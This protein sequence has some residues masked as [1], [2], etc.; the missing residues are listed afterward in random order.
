ME[1]GIAMSN[2]FIWVDTET[3]GLHT[4]AS[5]LEIAVVLTDADL[6]TICEGSWVILQSRNVAEL[7]D[8]STDYVKEMHTKNGLWIDVMNA[9][10]T[11]YE[12]QQIIIN[13]LYENK[14]DPQT[15]PLAGSTILFDRKVI[16]R[17]MPTLDE[18]AHYRSV[19]VSSIKELA[20]VWSPEVYKERPGKEEDKKVHRALDDV[21][22]SIE[23]LKYYRENFLICQ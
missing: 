16:Q 8:V 19:D 2:G 11:V 6:N 1:P 23:E 13:M 10:T 14:V 22:T 17:Y 4:W 21:K 7:Q 12:A 3:N 9:D 18:Y 20:K 5:L 15:L